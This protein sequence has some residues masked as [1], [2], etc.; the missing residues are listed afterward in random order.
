MR[1]KDKIFN[2]FVVWLTGGIVYY[3]AEILFSY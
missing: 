2:V 3:F 1:V